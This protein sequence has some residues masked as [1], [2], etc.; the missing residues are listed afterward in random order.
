MP[1][2]YNLNKIFTDACAQ[3]YRQD[4]FEIANFKI[5]E[6]EDKYVWKLKLYV[7]SYKFMI[8]FIVCCYKF[9]DC[10]RC[11]RDSVIC[12]TTIERVKINLI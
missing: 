9:C 11:L 5:Y 2:I 10:K 12:E 7:F 6:F 1:R 4:A 3:I 8:R